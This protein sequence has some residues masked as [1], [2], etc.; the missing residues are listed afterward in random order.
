MAVKILITGTPGVGKST[1]SKLIKNRVDASHIDIS[2]MIKKKKLYTKKCKKYDTF[3]Y[4]PDRVSAYLK[5]K[6]DPEKNYIIDTHDPESVSHI[7][8]DFII[9]LFSDLPVLSRRYTERGYS[10]KK[11]EEN[12]QVEI[13]E[14]IYNEVI[15]IFPSHFPNRVLRISSTNN[16]EPKEIEDIYKSI[17]SHSAWPFSISS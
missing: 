11:R 9:V 14:V 10:K 1:L 13:M 15:E 5:R 8:F 6:I 17:I 4:N 12:L 3:E 16:K 2:S 7:N